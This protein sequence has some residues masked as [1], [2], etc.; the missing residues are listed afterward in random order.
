[1][2]SDRPRNPKLTPHHFPPEVPTVLEFSNI[3]RDGTP[4]LTRGDGEYGPWVMTEVLYNGQP[5]AWFCPEALVA[6][7]EAFSPSVGSRVTVT[8]HMDGGK[9]VG[10]SLGDANA[11]ARPPAAK[12]APAP[13]RAATAPQRPQAG[14]VPTPTSGGWTPALVLGAYAKAH[15]VAREYYTDE[16]A[17]AA[18]AATLLIQFTRSCSPNAFS[19]VAN[20]PLP[21]PQA[22]PTPEVDTV[23]DDLPF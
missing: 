18:C 2:P 4:W 5:H 1:M 9:T 12:P 20:A 17:I 19:S 14:P 7:V 21:I 6:E 8:R 15:A 23:A 13:Q 22:D 3:G 16:E 10:W 11:P